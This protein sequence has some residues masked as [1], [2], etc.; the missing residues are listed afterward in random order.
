MASTG[1]PLWVR[2][3]ETGR[4]ILNYDEYTR[5]FSVESSTSGSPKRSIE[6]SRETALV[7]VD[8]PQLIQSFMDVNQW[9]EMFPCL[10][11][12]AATVDVIH[13]GEGAN[14]SGAVQLM[15]AELQMLTPM[16]PTRE[17]YFV[18]Y[19]KQLSAE[20]WAIV[21]V[22]IDKV[23]D[24]MDAASLVKCRKRP[25]G[26]IIEDKSN[27]HCKV[28]WVEHL[29]CQK[30][31]V[32]SLYRTI[33]SSGL[34]F[35]AR[36]WVVT[37]QLQCERLMFFMAT[38]VPTK[39][40]NG[41]V[42]TLAGRKSILKLAQRLTWSFCRALGASSS[43]NSWTKVPSKTGEDIRVASRKNLND[44]GEPIGVILSAVSSL[45]LP[46]SPTILFDFLRDD[47]RRHEWDIKAKGGQVQSIAHLAKGQDRGNIVTVQAI[48]SKENNSS[49]WVIQDSCTNAYESMV[50]YAHADMTG[51]Q[52]VMTGCDSSGMA[53]LPSG[54][55]I[56]SDGLESRPLL[57]TSRQ[58][59][60]KSSDS[61]GGS[62]LTIGLQIVTS[63][64]SPTAKVS[65]ESIT[66]IICC[67]LRNIKTSLRC[68]DG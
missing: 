67:T 58:D 25:S 33:V 31:T 42:A 59:Q 8:L 21:D 3:V 61:E 18:R 40:S 46:V 44:P 24:N 47:T 50:V 64:A 57:I 30:S 48:E 17:L 14:R 38:N 13:S 65:M 45:W 28:T 11:S 7:F 39:D 51:M 1:E 6:A 12:K 43:F 2:S 66:T 55:S 62:L 54:F 16:V 36:H 52:S 20:Q 22:S 68:E 23:E 15:F 63:A 49:M 34:A 4:E 56:L 9:K 10:V 60:E 35:G 37:L 32:H 26:C 29:Q 27:G 5:E 41:V 19:C 53:I